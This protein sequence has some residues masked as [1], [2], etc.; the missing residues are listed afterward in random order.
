MKVL[1]LPALVVLILLGLV[2]SVICVL[3]ALDPSFVLMA[4]MDETSLFGPPF[5]MTKALAWAVL[6]LFSSYVALVTLM[7]TGRRGT[8]LSLESEE[9]TTR[10]SVSALEGYIRRSVDEMA[11]V[12]PQK[13]K[14]NLK[15]LEF[16]VTLDC[17]V[18]EGKNVKNAN[19]L[20]RQ[21]IEELLVS[22]LGLP[23]PRCIEVN[24]HGFKEMKAS[25]VEVTETE[26]ETE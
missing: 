17:S 7:S 20:V 5:A 22:G 14:V 13:V 11:E 9:G 2:A 25:Q 4:S 18:A 16:S 19:T 8:Y 3:R 1:R 12:F 15:G 21:R 24:V 23:T 26:T 6:F 10:V